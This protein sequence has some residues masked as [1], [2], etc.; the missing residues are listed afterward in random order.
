[1]H[2]QRHAASSNGQISDTRAYHNIVVSYFHKLLLSDARPSLAKFNYQSVLINLFEKPAAKPVAG[3]ESTA[4][5]FSQS[6]C[7]FLICVHLCSSAVSV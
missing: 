4:D 3:C 1:M 5:F 7:R 2:S 6:L